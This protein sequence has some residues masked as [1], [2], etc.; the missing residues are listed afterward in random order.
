VGPE[1]PE[2]TRHAFFGAF[3]NPKGIDQLAGFV[4][5]HNNCSYG[6]STP[7]APS[8]NRDDQR[9]PNDQ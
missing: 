8:R 9:S 7:G 6:G 5:A 1:L 2:E 4:I 3:P